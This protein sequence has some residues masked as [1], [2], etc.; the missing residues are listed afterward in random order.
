MQARDG[1]TQMCSP[2]GI[3]NQQG[4]EGIFQT[5]DNAVNNWETGCCCKPVEAL[6]GA[7]PTE[8]SCDAPACQSCETAS[9]GNI[10]PVHY[11]DRGRSWSCTSGY[12]ST[13]V[14]VKFAPLSLSKFAGTPK[15]TMKCS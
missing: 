15:T 11:T 4:G 7:A 8:P 5:S 1:S 12:S 2:S 10:P 14:D 3:N 9:G 13:R 6:A